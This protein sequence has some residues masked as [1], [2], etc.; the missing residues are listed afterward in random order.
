MDRLAD[1]PPAVA[2]PAVFPY[3]PNRMIFHFDLNDYTGRTWFF[4]VH[5]RYEV[6]ETT[7]HVFLISVQESD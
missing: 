7:L 5:F 4:T 1:D 2:V 6:D 3:P